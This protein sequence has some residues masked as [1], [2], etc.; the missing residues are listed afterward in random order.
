MCIRDSSKCGG[1]VLRGVGTG[2]QLSC[3]GEVCVGYK[4]A[5]AVCAGWWVCTSA[6]GTMRA[7]G[8]GSGSGGRGRSAGGGGG[9]V[10]MMIVVVL[11]VWWWW[12]WW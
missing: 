5:V 7:G 11:V 3:N 6:P 1:S 12:C 10:L 8:G 2:G 4:V 9:G